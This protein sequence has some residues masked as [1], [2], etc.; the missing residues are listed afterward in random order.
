MK[1]QRLKIKQNCFLHKCND[2]L[3]TLV[4]NRFKSFKFKLILLLQ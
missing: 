2:R 3:Q 4:L 1:S